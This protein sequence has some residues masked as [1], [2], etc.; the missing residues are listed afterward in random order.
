MRIEFGS[1]PEQTV[2]RIS[3]RRSRNLW[4]LVLAGGE[5]SRLQ[6]ITTGA[7]GTPVPKQ[8]CSLVGGRTLLQDAIAR[9]HSVVAPE[10]TCTIVSDTHRQWWA[11]LLTR[12]P[13]GSVIV[14]PHGRGTGIGILY[15]ALHI[16]ARDPDARILIL[17][18]DHHVRYERELTTALRFAVSQIDS[19]ESAP[20]LLGLQPDSVDSELGY[21]VPASSCVEAPAHVSRFVEKP[22]L[23]AAQQV[24][25]TEGAL[26][27][28]FIIAT[29]VRSLVRLFMKQFSVAT[30]EMQAIVN[31]ALHA[32]PAESAWPSVVS[33]F[34]RLAPVDFS[35]D[36]L[37]RM[38]EALQ[39][40]RIPN[41]GWNDL[42][43]PS[44][45]GATLRTLQ[46]RARRRDSTPF[47]NLALQHARYEHRQSA[48]FSA[49]GI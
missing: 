13:P 20:L 12:Q 14:Q 41:C 49:Q 40:L 4:A 16:A 26:W 11:R 8:F 43:T 37:Q 3:S 38:P 18:S 47:I 45:L 15:S 36:I 5:G 25:E 27:N 6:Q 22:D 39:V 44:R 48:G 24:I 29:P 33:M 31:A 2:R 35:R 46:P 10:R 1:P 30:L 34:E 7:D 17:P 19:A 28:T 42:G 9:A 23:D 21:I 32:V